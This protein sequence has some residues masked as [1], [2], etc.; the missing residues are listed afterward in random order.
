NDP[1]LYT[2][3]KK[4]SQNCHAITDSIV[5]GRGTFAQMLADTAFYPK[6]KAITSKTDSLLYKLHNHGTA[7]RLLNDEQ[8]YENLVSLVRSLDSLSTD[9][10]K[11]PGRYV[12]VKVF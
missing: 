9:L 7:A 2:N 8:L 1:G 3:V 12:Q 10:K 5:N 4:S 6:L 11:N